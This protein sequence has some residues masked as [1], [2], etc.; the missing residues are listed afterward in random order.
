[1][2]R[3]RV[4]NPK[5][6]SPR[7]EKLSRMP[8]RPQPQLAPV[9]Q[10]NTR[11]HVSVLRIWNVTTWQL[12][13]TCRSVVQCLLGPIP[14]LCRTFLYSKTQRLKTTFPRCPCNHDTEGKWSSIRMR[15]GGQKGGGMGVGP[16]QMDFTGTWD[17]KWMALRLLLRTAWTSAPQGGD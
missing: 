1:M 6:D 5:L 13:G 12:G 10:K 7:L 8:R 14:L 11:A 16:R 17:A 2:I 15:F 3:I 4:S 9:T